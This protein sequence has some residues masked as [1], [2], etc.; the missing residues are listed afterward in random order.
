MRSP[1]LSCLA[2]DVGALAVDLDDA[3][4]GLVAGDVGQALGAHLAFPEVDVGAAEGR[5]F[6]LREGAAFLKLGHANV[7]YFDRTVALG[8]D[9]GAWHALSFNGLGRDASAMVTAPPLEA[10]RSLA[11]AANDNVQAREMLAFRS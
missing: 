10:T 9:G 2:E 5:G 4:G 11:I 3:A 8:H 1:A 6:D 7:L